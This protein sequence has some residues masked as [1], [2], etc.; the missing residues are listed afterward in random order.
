L[1]PVKRFGAGGARLEVLR[2][3]YRDGVPAPSFLTA[4]ERAALRSRLSPRSDLRRYLAREAVNWA[5]S[6][7]NDVDAAEA[8]RWRWK[9]RGG[10][11]SAQTSVASKARS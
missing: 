6:R 11:A 10:D 9:E 2:L 1:R 3:V 4:D 5:K 7:R 8:P